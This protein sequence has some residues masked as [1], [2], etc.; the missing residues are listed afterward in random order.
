MEDHRRTHQ[1]PT[2]AQL[3]EHARAL[4]SSSRLLPELRDR[5]SSM[6]SRPEEISGLLRIDAGMTSMIL[7][8]ANSVAFSRGERCGSIDEAVTRVGY[9][10]I[11]RMVTA[12]VCRDL[13]KGDLPFYGISAGALLRDSL[14]AAIAATAI[15][16]KAAYG[17]NGDVFYTA[18]ML[19][20]SG[21]IALND[22][23]LTAGLKNTS[24][25]VPTPDFERSIFGYHYAEMGAAMMEHWQFGDDIIHL[26]YQQIQGE[27]FE[28]DYAVSIFR[29]GLEAVPYV[30]NRQLDPKPFVEQPAVQLLGITSQKLHQALLYSQQMFEVFGSIL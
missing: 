26:V 22:Y 12:V 8:L 10:E 18:G 17:K 11:F 9:D 7:R 2:L 27:M 24:G 4:P 29:L 30:Q 6:N 21:K 15:N 1:F 23:A 25:R 5:L 28:T 13:L 16:Q 20:A 3:L 19:H 14:A